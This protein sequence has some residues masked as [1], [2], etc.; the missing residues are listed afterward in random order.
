[1]TNHKPKHMQHKQSGAIL[2]TSLIFLLVLSMLVLAALRTGTLEERM[3]ANARNRQVALQAAE[4]VLRNAEVTLFTGTAFTSNF[5]SYPDSTGNL[6]NGFYMAPSSATPLKWKSVDWSDASK[7]LTNGAALG[8]VD[9]QPRYIVEIITRPTRPNS[10]V[11]CSKGLLAVTAR[12]LGRDAA[13]VFVHAM[14]RYQ[15]D[16]AADGC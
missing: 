14:Y 8:G 7:T 6:S 12:G 9:T 16:R 11:P 5:D 13:D 4:A 2:F 10:T 3:A 15:S 1:M